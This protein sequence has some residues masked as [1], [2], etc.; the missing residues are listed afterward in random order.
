MSS[1]AEPF[2]RECYFVPVPD[3]I[4]EYDLPVTGALPAQLSGV[5]LRNGPNPRTASAA[6]YFFGDGMIHGVRLDAGQA[7][8]YRSRY[9][10]TRRDA[11]IRG[12]G[13]SNT[14]VFAHAGRVLS[15]VE[16]ALPMEIDRSLE[17]VARSISGA[18]T[19]PS[20]RTGRST[21]GRASSWPSATSARAPTSCST[22]S[23]VRDSSSSG[24]P[25]K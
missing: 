10:K 18:S 23:T 2:V 7:R 15:F 1:A 19:R 8:W 6:H 12:G 24:G 3:E 20:P 13:S 14:H 4:A 21:R 17:T 9:V 25:S 11:G 16:A 22:G 5:Y